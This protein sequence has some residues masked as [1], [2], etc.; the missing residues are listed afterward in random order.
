[1]L[2]M[3]FYSIFYTLVAL[4]FTGQI[5]PALQFCMKF[6]QINFD[7]LIYLITGVSGQYFVYKTMM[8]FGIL[9]NS[10]VTTTRKVFTILLSVF[11]FRHSLNIYQWL[12]II[13]VFG[14]L[15]VDLWIENREYL[16]KK[17]EKGLEKREEE[18]QEINLE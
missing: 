11:W 12:G 7:I 2:Y 8:S 1:M 15:S 16:S 14:S 3:N 6:P 10:I 5:Q 9:F 17:D 13:I 4:L 18:N